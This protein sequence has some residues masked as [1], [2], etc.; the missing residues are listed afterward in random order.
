MISGFFEESI[1]KRAQDKKL[2]EIEIINLRDFAIDDYGTVDDRPYG[3]G[4]G[5]ILRVDVIYKALAKVESEKLKVKNKSQNLKVLLTSPKGKVFDQ[6]KAQEYSKLD[7]LIIIAGHYEGVDERVLDYIDEETSL[8]DFVLT[9]GEI[10]AAAIVDSVVRL[11]HGVL[12]KDQATKNESFD[13]NSK[14]ILEYP[15]YTRP[16]IF[17][18]KKVPKILLS[19]DHKKIKD[20]QIKKAYE[21][22]RKKRPDLLDIV[23]KKD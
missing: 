11:I 22:T 7:H 23:K 8:G 6:K 13:I 15:Q 5:M 1:I 20:W 9:G 14:K 17:K 10:P 12:K 2:V 18:N 21:E 16:E 3:G 4:T 19:G